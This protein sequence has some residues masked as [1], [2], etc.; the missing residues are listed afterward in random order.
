[1]RFSV[2]RGARN[3]G[4]KVLIDQSDKSLPCWPMLDKWH[5]KID[6]TIEC[7]YVKI[8]NWQAVMSDCL[9]RFGISG[10]GM[11][12][13]K[14]DLKRYMQR[15]NWEHPSSQVTLRG[16]SSSP[17]VRTDE[18][19]SSSDVTTKFSRFDG[20]PISLTNGSSLTHFTRWSSAIIIESIQAWKSHR[21]PKY[22]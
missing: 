20:L 12:G 15:I 13:C 21:E 3:L 22:G 11:F 5:L 18:G 19:R 16:P 7:K 2:A 9:D 10:F 14:S 4:T 1:M 6:W 8:L 17:R